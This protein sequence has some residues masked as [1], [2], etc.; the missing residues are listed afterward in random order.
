[1][2]T[3][4][5]DVSS[6]RPLLEHAIRARTVEKW[7]ELAI[8]FAEKAANQVAEAKQH[9]EN[10]ATAAA[11]LRN[12]ISELEAKPG[13]GEIME[14][15]IVQLATEDPQTV[16]ERV[17]QMRDDFLLLVSALNA[18]RDY[19]AA[20]EAQG[21]VIQLHKFEEGHNITNAAWPPV[22]DPEGGLKWFDQ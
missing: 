17:L 19:L 7:C 22:A 15:A 13:H 8:E 16:A 2:T 10:N 18:G 20:L 12:R 21:I 14:G 4:N 5:L 9:A 6:L 3:M 1:M 11:K